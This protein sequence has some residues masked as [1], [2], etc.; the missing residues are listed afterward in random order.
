MIG[1]DWTHCSDCY[2]KGLLVVWVSSPVL[3]KRMNA[4]QCPRCRGRGA[5]KETVC[6][7]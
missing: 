6:G 3:G 5:Y 4:Y 1:W 7:S 2:G